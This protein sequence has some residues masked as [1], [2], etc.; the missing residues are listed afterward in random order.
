[1]L[2]AGVNFEQVKVDLTPVSQLKV[3]LPNFPLSRK[4]GEDDVQLL[5]KVEQEARNTVDGY[6]CTEHEVC[7]ASLPNNGCL[8]YVLKVAGVAYGPR[9]VHVSVEVPNKRKTDV[10]VKVSAKR[11]KV[12]ILVCLCW[13]M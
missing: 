13:I 4:G 12:R 8:N 5:A 6:T 1:M 7:V 10:A 11:P 3:P 2:T 9:P